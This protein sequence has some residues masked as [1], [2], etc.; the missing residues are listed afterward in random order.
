MS[1][2]PTPNPEAELLEW[3]REQYP[4]VLRLD[5][6]SI[7]AICPLMF[8]TSVILGCNRHGYSQ[9]FCFENRAYAREVFD[10]LKS[11]DDEPTGWIARRP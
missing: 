4:V 8:T 3:L 11:E 2:T 7:A 6:G 9:R 5:D 1:Q 10:N